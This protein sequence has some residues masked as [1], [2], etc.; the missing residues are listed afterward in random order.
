MKLLPLTL[1]YCALVGCAVTVPES[2]MKEAGDQAP[3]RWSATREGQAGIDT[4]WVSRI[5]GSGGA[6]L[7]DEALSANPDMRVAAERVN[8]AIATSRTAAAAMRPTVEAG[9]NGARSKQVFVGFPFGDGG[10]PSSLSENYGASLSVNWE[11]DIWGFA[12]AGQ[13]ALI[14]DA[15]SEGQNYRAARASLAAQVIR[16]WLALAEANEQIVLA[17]TSTGLF[18]QTMDIVRDRFTNALAEEGGS[19]SQFRLAES[20]FESSKATLAQRK[21]E[22]EQAIRQLEL[23]LGR[24]PAGAI[25]SSEKLPSIPPMPPA[26]LPSELLLRRPDILAAER[27]FASS[28]SL[29]KQGK[30]AFYPSIK[31]TASGGTTTDS[32]SN[33]TNS[34]FGVWRLAGALSQP[35]WAGGALRSEYSRLKSD[36]RA[37][38]ASLQSTVLNAFGEVEQA[39]VA[40]RFMAQRGEATAAALKSATE[41]AEA[42]NADYAGGTGDALTLITAQSNRITLASQLVTLRRLRLDNRD[43][44]HLALGGDYRVGKK[45]P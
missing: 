15:Q 16:A 25:R 34:D 8:R 30:L 37:A 4:R 10:V 38:L 17:E 20:Q 43:S 3:G 2:R 1:V 12:R 29:L 14:A 24:Y 6:S 33:I 9:L 18:Q 27:R 41:A 32:L 31:I 13:S 36:D 21:G 35:I 42:A 11:P 44:L 28:G 23:L 19:A 45:S 7:V 26:G 5:G 39:L 40:D 22:R